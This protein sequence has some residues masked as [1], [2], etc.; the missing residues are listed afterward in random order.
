MARLSLREVAAA[1]ALAVGEPDSHPHKAHMGRAPRW[2]ADSLRECSCLQPVHRVH[3][4]Q[5]L[6]ELPEPR[7]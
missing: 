1:K 5:A 6:Q 3:V 2:G 4:E 7:E